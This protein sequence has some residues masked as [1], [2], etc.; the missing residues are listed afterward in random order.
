MRVLNAFIGKSRQ[1]V[2]KKVLRV[3][4]R[5]RFAAKWGLFVGVGTGPSK[6]GT[7]QRRLSVQMAPRAATLCFSHAF[8]RAW[9]VSKRNSLLTRVHLSR[10][11]P[12]DPA[13]DQ[14]R[15]LP[16]DDP[17]RGEQQP[18]PQPQARAF[19]KR[20]RQLPPSCGFTAAR[21]TFFS[22]PLVPK[23]RHYEER[24]RE[25]RGWPAIPTTTT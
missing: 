8:P 4:V 2:N 11:P 22:S 3:G 19:R 24:Q 17:S 7:R 5:L 6:L 9:S 14:G 15:V 18:Q 16:G 12:A 20:A 25:K 10:R 23:R 13:H 21:D 1:P